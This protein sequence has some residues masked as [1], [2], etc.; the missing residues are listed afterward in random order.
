M[1][2][3]ELDVVSC[4]FLD[5][6]IHKL[7]VHF[8]QQRPLFETTADF[9][10]YPYEATAG[11]RSVAT[12]PGRVIHTVTV[13][14]KV[15][16]IIFT[17]TILSLNVVP[18]PRKF[19]RN[20]TIVSRGLGFILEETF[21]VTGRERVLGSFISIYNRVRTLLRSSNSMTLAI[22]SMIVSAAVV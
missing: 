12:F 9:C 15:K 8:K 4:Q 13:V 14:D 17:A 7:M 16:S 22:F 11:W 3:L 6:H 10:P 5:K 20:T 21:L 18:V 1:Y 19:Q 2:L